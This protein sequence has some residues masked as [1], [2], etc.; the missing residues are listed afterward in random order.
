M[1]SKPT[2][3]LRLPLQDPDTI[4]AILTENNYQV[5]RLREYRLRNTKND[6]NFQK[7]TLLLTTVYLSDDLVRDARH[8]ATNLEDDIH[9]HLPTH[10]LSGHVTPSGLR[11]LTALASPQE[12]TTVHL[13]ITSKR[14]PDRNALRAALTEH[15]FRTQ[16]TAEYA[17]P[18]PSWTVQALFTGTSITHALKN[19]A[20]I[21]RQPILL[22]IPG[23][24]LRT[25]VQPHQEP[26]KTDRVSTAAAATI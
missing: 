9:L 6:P 17:A 19:L 15:H 23:L 2:V 7:N 11:N 20:S 18:E 16:R 14:V 1:L 3:M 4:R 24:Q 22:R 13:R 8:A 25:W 21:T 10:N 12:G 26:R 5:T